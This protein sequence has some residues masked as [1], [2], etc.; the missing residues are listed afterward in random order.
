[1]IF[2]YKYQIEGGEIKEGEGEAPDKFALY[3]QLK[4][5][6][7]AV[8]SAQEK[9]PKSAFKLGSITIFSKVS[10]RD[11]INFARNMGAMLEAGLALSR[12]L[13]VMERQTKN[14]KFKTLIQKT[15][16]NIKAGK[17]LSDS[18]KEHGKTFSPLFISMVKAGE[19]G[20]TLVQALKILSTQMEKSYLLGKRLKGALIYPAVIIGV[21]LVIAV[22]MLMFVVPTLTS[23]FKELNVALPFSTRVVIF[24]SDFLKD[25]TVI[26]L[27][28]FLV[29]GFSLF[30]SL[31]T[32]KGKR[33]FDYVV[34]RIPV[35]GQITKETNSARTAR[36]L[37]SLLSSGVEFVLAIDITGDVLQNSY[38]KEVLKEARVKVEKGEPISDIFEKNEALYPV[39]VGEMMSVG[40]ETGKLGEM[41]VG[42][43]DFYE[44]EVDQKTKDMSTIIEP[45]LMVFIGIAVGFFAISMITPMYTLVDA[46]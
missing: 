10:T 28:L 29:V 40:E 23:T 9:G 5:D 16:D 32:K 6:G 2:K 31:K 44:N 7:I 3:R 8:V 4:K 15:N 45:V 1:M 18:L 27:I 43:A 14:K 41:L 39:F 19:E 37:S 22:L 34:L 42:V 12:I 17:P 35:I 25:N 38:Y 21:M 11:K 20:G 13:S 46:I 26:A 33:I 24:V 30:F 36:T